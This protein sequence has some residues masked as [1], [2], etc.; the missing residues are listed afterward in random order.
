MVVT[1]TIADTLTRIRNASAVRH[2]CVVVPK[3]KIVINLVKLLEKEGF[4]KSFE[5]TN[6]DLGHPKILIVLKYEGRNSEPSIRTLK[7]VSRPGLR[8]YTK[9]KSIPQVIGGFGVAI[10]STSQGLM[11]G[12]EAKSRNLG[13]EIL[14]YVW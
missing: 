8:K 11:T 12:V 13:G 6:D 9:S 4:I 5:V 2:Q 14:C 3:T 10:L 7:R 1:D